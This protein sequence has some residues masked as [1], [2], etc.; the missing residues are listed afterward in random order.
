MTF[1]TAR[2]L[3]K[4]IEIHRLENERNRLV[5]ALEHVPQ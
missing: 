5:A 1:W 2:V 4:C 3:E